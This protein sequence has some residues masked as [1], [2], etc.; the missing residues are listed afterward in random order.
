MFGIRRAEHPSQF[1]AGEGHML[2]CVRIKLN[3]RHGANTLAVAIDVLDGAASAAAIGRPALA[4]AARPLR[5][6]TAG[7]RDWPARSA[8]RGFSIM[9]CTPAQLFAVARP[10]FS[11]GGQVDTAR[12]LKVGGEPYDASDASQSLGRFTLG[13]ND[14][15]RE[16]DGVQMADSKDE[17]S[18]RQ[19]GFE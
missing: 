6:A 18:A 1:V 3:H 11:I 2:R 17:Q 16:V 19:D 4:Q 5:Y 12:R 13:S 10:P 14:L 9:G 7:P 15:R 8:W